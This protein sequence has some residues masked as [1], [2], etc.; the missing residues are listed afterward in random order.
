[1]FIHHLE[2]GLMDPSVNVG[3]LIQFYLVSINISNLSAL[4]E[5]EKKTITLD[6]YKKK[7]EKKI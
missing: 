6:R 5:F 1:V 7:Y 2:V 3:E 4:Y